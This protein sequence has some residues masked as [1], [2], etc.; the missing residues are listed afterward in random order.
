[1]LVELLA[2]PRNMLFMIRFAG[3]V[4]L[5]GAALMGTA[6]AQEVAFPG[7]QDKARQS[8]AARELDLTN[9]KDTGFVAMP[10]PIVD[11][12]ISDG[13]GAIGL[14]PYKLDPADTI[15]PPSSTL[16]AAGYTS[17][18][19]WYVG[20]VQ[21]FY[22]NDDRFRFDG[23]LAYADLNLEFFSIGS[24]SSD[25]IEYNIKGVVAQPKLLARVY[26]NVYL[27]GIFS[28]FGGDV[29]FKGARDRPVPTIGL[30]STTTGLGPVPSNRP[31]DGSSSTASTRR[32]PLSARHG[33]RIAPP[34][35]QSRSDPGCPGQIKS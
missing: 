28:Y 25:S 31:Q 16:L 22:W 4:F 10:L 35:S 33:S 14:Y 11:P 1:M 15:S 5:T 23:L 19:S 8:D 32:V 3:T 30:S 24:S 29:S 9:S 18:E 6:P 12:T 21:K 17:T 7:V 26:P 34:A 27:G 2:R 13:I 20:G